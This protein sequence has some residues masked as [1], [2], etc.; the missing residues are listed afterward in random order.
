MNHLNGEIY[1]P[2]YLFNAN[3]A[4]AVRPVIQQAPL[5]LSPGQ[6]FTVRVDNPANIR[7]RW[8]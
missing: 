2:G 8:R 6:T 1:T 4:A 7:T 5:D 3:G